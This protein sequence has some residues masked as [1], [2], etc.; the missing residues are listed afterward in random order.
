MVHGLSCPKA[1]GI[2]IP[3]PGIE[4]VSPALVGGFLT[5]GPPGKS[6]L[7]LIDR[8]FDGDG[9]RRLGLVID[10]IKH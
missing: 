1:C 4:P 2:L 8:A 10:C 3:G 9:S 6:L 7:R 5:T